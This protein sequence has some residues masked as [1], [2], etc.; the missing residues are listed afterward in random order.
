MQTETRSL[1]LPILKNWIVAT[2]VTLSYFFVSYLLIGFRSEQLILGLIFTSFYVATPASRKFI[3]GFSIFIVF[4]II[5]DYMKAFP[6][7]L[8]NDVQI[9]SLYETERLLFGISSGGVI[10]T[11]N[12]YLAAHSHTSFDLLTG[13][14]Y[15]CWIPAPLALAGY[16]FYYDR[17]LF[18]Q[19]SLTFLLANLIGFVVYYLFPTAP[20]W[21]VQ[22]YGFDFVAGTPGHTAGLARFDQFF[23]IH[24]FESM[25]AKSSNVFAAMPSLHSAYPFIAFYYAVKAKLRW[26]SVVFGIITAG[27]WISAVYSGH[28]Y[29]L[30]VL[31]GVL[32]ASIGIAIFNRLDTRN[33]FFRKFV[34][35]YKR[36]IS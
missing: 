15:L 35:N 34:D 10:Q 11:P 19:F 23:G 9:R 22:Y 25:Y 1:Q 2:G 12:E 24:L 5:F 28:H 30:D 21:Y 29:V 31:A 36:T 13:L 6:N 17:R 26:T 20:P 8:Y 7:Y 33:N 16:L 4:W 32:C 14:F 3:L 18:L 27:I